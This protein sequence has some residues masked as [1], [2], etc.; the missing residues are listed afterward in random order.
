M[1]NYCNRIQDSSCITEFE[2][3]RLQAKDAMISRFCRKNVELNPLERAIVNESDRNVLAY[4]SEHLNLKV[5]ARSIILTTSR[6]SYLD[7]VD[8]DNV[9]AIVNLEQSSG[10]VMTDKLLKAVNTLL[11]DAGIYIGLSHEVLDSIAI[12][13]IFISNGFEIIDITTINRSLYFT[14]MKTGTTALC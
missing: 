6:Y 10:T 4:I 8:F 7:N 12:C 11:P 3:H 2:K 9:R 1:K 5:N 13:E 14:V